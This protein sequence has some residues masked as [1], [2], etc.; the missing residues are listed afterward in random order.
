MIP[1][2]RLESLVDANERREM[3][4][5]V[6]AEYRRPYLLRHAQCFDK[7]R[8]VVQSHAG[9]VVVFNGALGGDAVEGIRRHL[10]GSEQVHLG[11]GDGAEASR[12]S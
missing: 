10:L 9:D 5:T 6:V 8:V 7:F 11:A 3:L 2:P 12:G 1:P 4:K